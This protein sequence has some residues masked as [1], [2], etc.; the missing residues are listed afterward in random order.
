MR[1]SLFLDSACERLVGRGRAGCFRFEG[2]GEE[3]ERGTRGIINVQLLVKRVIDSF[4]SVGKSESVYVCASI[5]GQSIMAIDQTHDC[6]STWSK[7]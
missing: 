1:A 6:L 5:A 4:Q 7:I 2:T 3:R